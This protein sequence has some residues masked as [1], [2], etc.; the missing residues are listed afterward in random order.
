MVA[1]VA[2]LEHNNS[3]RYASGFSNNINLVIYLLYKKKVLVI[4][5]FIIGLG[6]IMQQFL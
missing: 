6:F 1:D 2:Q 3:K 5:R 4:Y